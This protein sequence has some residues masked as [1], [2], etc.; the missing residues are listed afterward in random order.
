MNLKS[1]LAAEKVSNL[2]FDISNKDTFQ[3][4]EKLKTELTQTLLENNKLLEYKLQLE[5]HINTINIEQRE[6]QLKIIEFKKTIKQQ[7]ISYQHLLDQQSSQEQ[8][9]NMNDTDDEY[10]KYD[11]HFGVC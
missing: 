2:E 9:I 11:L 10:D 8:K 4:C 5:A 7:N 6:N 3:K 1:Q